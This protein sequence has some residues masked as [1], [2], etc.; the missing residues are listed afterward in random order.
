M[1][2]F[3]ASEQSPIGAPPDDD[4]DEMRFDGVEI[5]VT[6]GPDVTEHAVQELELPKKPSWQIW[7]WEDVTAGITPTTP[8]LDCGVILRA[9][10]RDDGDDDVTIKLRPCR[11]S[12]L[13]DRWLAERKGRTE[14]GD[15]WDLKLEADWS[16]DRSVLATS[17][18]CDRPADVV[19]AAGRGSRP[20]EDLFTADQLDFLQDCSGTAINLGTLA[21]LPPVTATRWNEVAAAPNKLDVRAERWTVGDLDFLELSVVA[22]LEKARRSQAA[23]NAFVWSR[24]LA[25]GSQQVSKTRQVLDHLVARR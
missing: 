9:R 17:F 21:V 23:L 10:H 25:I 24:G 16:G 22:D 8:L 19:Q 2:R 6:L 18:T 15:A 1:R 14:D 5:K 3:L 11:R 13:T 4:E 12:Q 7:F 20:V